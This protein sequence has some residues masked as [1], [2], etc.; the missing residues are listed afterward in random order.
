[1][2][3]GAG[4]AQAE[5]VILSGNNVIRIENLEVFTDQGGPELYDVEFIYSTATNVYG[6]NLNFPFTQEEESANAMK[7]VLNALNA[8]NPSPKGAGPNGTSQFWLGE[9]VDKKTGFIGAW[10]GEYFANTDFWDQCERDCALGAGA[11]GPLENA[12]YLKFTPADGTSPPPSGNVNLSGDVENTSGT[13]LCAMV[14]ASGKFEFSCDPN[15]PF[16]L[17]D[18][19]RESDNTV[20]RQV[21][22]DGSYP[23]IKVLQ[24]SVNE[25]VVMTRAVNCPNYN[26]PY[27]PGTS[28]GDAG[29]R[30]NISGTILLQNS[31]TPVCAMVL[32]NGAFEFSCNGSGTYSLNIPLDNNGQFKL[33]VYA[34]GFA[35]IIQ[36]FDDSS[37][38][39]DV[40]LA[41]A[42]ECQ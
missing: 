20:K 13:G 17:T 26:Q 12:T 24:G 35:P 33:Q 34:D 5:Q 14:L 38:M 29:K 4:M 36:R 32:A 28:P 41:R 6:S 2:L 3:F 18:L 10:G 15:G 19:P 9:D 11:L 1:L 25:T 31:G 42:A 27:S 23:N 21:Y 40:R 22:V 30:V 39:N 8:N 37:V 7:Q 16:S